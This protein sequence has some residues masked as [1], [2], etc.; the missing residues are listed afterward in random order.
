LGG[1]NEK[2]ITMKFKLLDERKGSIIKI[3]ILK[4]YAL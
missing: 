3:I 1:G 4:G 2:N